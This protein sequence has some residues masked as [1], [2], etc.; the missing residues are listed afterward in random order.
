MQDFEKDFP[1]H[2]HV[3][4]II[5]ESAG[6]H[7]KPE[8]EISYNDSPQ[9]VYG[10]NKIKYPRHLLENHTLKEFAGNYGHE[11][12]H[13]Q[14]G[15]FERMA[16]HNLLKANNRSVLLAGAIFAVA[17][18]F[19]NGEFDPTKLLLAS[20]MLNRFGDGIANNVLV[21]AS[22][23]RADLYQYNLTGALPSEN[24]LLM[25]TLSRSDGIITFD[26][27][28]ITLNIKNKALNKLITGY[29]TPKERDEHVLKHGNPN[30]DPRLLELFSIDAAQRQAKGLV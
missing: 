10:A 12:A 16:M 6:I 3:A 11:L 2:K 22:E 30:P 26:G 17:K 19:D 23:K 21:A 14:N 9:A 13:L 7:Q 27:D 4:E 24:L 28:R 8:I 29:P 1:Q 18:L 25:S 15:E 20:T 5:N